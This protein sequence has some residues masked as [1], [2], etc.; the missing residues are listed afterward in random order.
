MVIE[1]QTVYR[2]T[3]T[4]CGYSWD[5]VESGTL[6]RMMFP[7]MVKESPLM[8]CPKCETQKAIKTATEEGE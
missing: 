5:S 1:M 8:G 6:S 7:G 4:Q 3:C 2:F